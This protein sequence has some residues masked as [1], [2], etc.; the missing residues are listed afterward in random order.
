MARSSI[1]CCLA[2]STPALNCVNISPAWVQYDRCV[3][4]LPTQLLYSAT[5]FSHR[6]TCFVP[7]L[8]T[9]L[10]PSS[11]E[12]YF[13][14]DGGPTGV[15]GSWIAYGYAPYHSA[16]VA[17]LL[18]AVS[19]NPNLD[20][21]YFLRL[22]NPSVSD[23]YDAKQKV[24]G[25]YTVD[26][27]HNLN[28]FG[29]DKLIFKFGDLNKTTLGKG[30]LLK[31]LES[32][33]FDLEID[34]LGWIGGLRYIGH[35]YS[36]PGDYALF[37]GKT[38]NNNLGGYLFC[39]ID[40]SNYFR[41]YTN[42]L[43][44]YSSLDFHPIEIDAEA[45]FGLDGQFHSTLPCA[46]LIAPKISLKAPSHSLE[47]RLTGRYYSQAFDAWF[48]Q[49]SFH[50]TYHGIEEEAQDFDNWRNYL[51]N[52][53]PVSNHG[54]VSGSGDAK[55]VSSRVKGDQ[56]IWDALWF[57]G[58]IEWARQYYSDRTVDSTFYRFGG[59]IR[60]SEYQ[61]LYAGLN[62]KVLMSDAAYDYSKYGS[63]DS[64]NRDSFSGYNVPVFI[65]AN[66]F[67]EMG[68]SIAF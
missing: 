46:L 39:S 42:I 9:C 35:G 20:I 45:A 63:Y 13:T 60:L 24:V 10:P 66:P 53:F 14:I 44:G 2:A 59:E 21:Y 17:D 57:Y 65:Q 34:S 3:I 43:G 41:T 62:N 49:F 16:F 23:G 26:F 32:Q 58:D 61:R 1:P 29:I 15:W 30:L 22:E 50:K 54:V 52:S 55:G 37:Y 68:A 6:T 27:H 33:G 12:A 5:H 25:R 8:T 28:I 31:D 64:H 51:I 7:A 18:P 56:Q 67:F 47:I 19:V 48:Q 36:D 40:D 11:F 38:K 4:P